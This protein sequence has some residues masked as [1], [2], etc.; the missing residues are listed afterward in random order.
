MISKILLATDGSAHSE[1]ALNYARY[2]AQELGAEVVV[3]NA[4]HYLPD[5]VSPSTAEELL[6]G[7]REAAQAIVDR[8]AS[9]L[10]PA[11]ILVKAMIAQGTAAEEILRLA[12]EE[13]C[14]MIVVGSR[15]AGEVA[16]MLI[17]SVSQRVATHAKKPVLIVH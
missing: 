8:A 9:E 14:D 12:D 15:G 13:G 17:G 4:Y 10:E 16:G 3:F 1:R 11:G 7:A 5:Y 6:R 2:L